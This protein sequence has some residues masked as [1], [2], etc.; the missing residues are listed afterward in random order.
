LGLGGIPGTQHVHPYYKDKSPQDTLPI[1][2]CYNHLAKIV[3]AGYFQLIF[4]SAA[5]ENDSWGRDG[6]IMPRHHRTAGLI[7]ISYQA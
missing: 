3:G 7:K 4:L 6:E 5:M 1:S 2:V